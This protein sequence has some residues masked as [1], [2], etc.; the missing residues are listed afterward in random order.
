MIN[1]RQNGRRRGRGG[2]QQQPRS[3]GGGGQRDSGNRIDSRARGNA[4]QLHEKYR[5]MARDAQMSGDR[6]NTEYYLQFAD[7]YFRV[8]ADQRGRNEDQGHQRRGRDDFDQDDDFGFEGEPVRA[9]EQTR[10]AE[11]GRRDENRGDNNY[12]R[13]DNYQRE[14]AR[15]DGGQR[16]GYQRDGQRE[17]NQRDGQRDGG[18]RD[19]GQRDNG[20]RDGNREQ[21]RQRDGN[22]D[23]GQRDNGQRESGQRESGNRYEPRRRDEQPRD[24]DRASY[25]NGNDEQR[26]AQVVEAPVETG[27][28]PKRR[29]RPRKQPAAAPAGETQDTGF[30]AAVLP[31]SL[32]ISFANDAEPETDAPKPRRRRTVKASATGVDAAE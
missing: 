28:E 15:R 30:D 24:D 18:Q 29:G 17:N 22:R 16:E 6:V 14:G 19:A 25:A 27:A 1:N 23:A 8:L 4:T 13:N 31:P 2:G 12:Q 32:S 7:H 20:Q 3:G 11:D 9:D 10:V 21:G 5:N 26:A